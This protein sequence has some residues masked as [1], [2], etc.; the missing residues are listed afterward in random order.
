MKILLITNY[1]A[2]EIGAASH[3]F[4]DLAAELTRQGHR[5]SVV[6]GFPR[7]NITKADLP[8]RYRT[9]ALT[10]REEI[11]GIKVY[12]IKTAPL[13]KNI[14]VARGLDYLTVAASLLLCSFSIEKH[15]VALVYSPPLFLGGSAW[16]LRL[17][18]G[19]PFVLNVQDLFPQ[20]AIDLGLLTS[21]RL[22][23][24]FEKLEKWLYRKA[25]CVTV[26]SSGNAEHVKT[27]TGG[28]IEAVVMPNW[29]DTEGLQPG[30]RY[31]QFSREQ[32]LDDKFV[33]S[34]AGTLGYSQDIGVMVRAAE[35]LQD[36]PDLL[37]LIVGDGV[38]KDEWMEK[39]AHLKNVRWLPMQTRE[40]YAQVLHA[41]EICLAT[42]RT[43]VK[44]PVVP[45]KILSIMSAG[46]PI[47]ATM[48]LTGDA[49]A[50]IQDAN[51][52]Y[53]LPAEDDTQLAEAI[54]TL[55]QDRALAQVMGQSGREYVVREYSLA[56]GAKRYLEVFRQAQP[57][58]WETPL[59]GLSHPVGR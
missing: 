4:Y 41:S 39:S 53:A 57:I 14:P 58:R 28:E 31:N 48:E 43:A 26:H 9:R 22:I 40:V 47:I 18:K 45:S 44:T 33:V 19:T 21:P 32:G 29:V 6:T 1:F 24:A 11:D 51:C 2:P 30:E 59:W 34:F 54:R 23:A 38:Q 56:A 37:F 10:M 13:P 27:V 7:Y 52:G 17:L 15:D 49:P 42:L 55:Y 35:R 20:S 16:L 25:D 3:L 50:I 5:V 46:K 12:R 36:L 8:K